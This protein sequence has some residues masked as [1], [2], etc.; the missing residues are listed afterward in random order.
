MNIVDIIERISELVEKSHN[1]TVF[2]MR[3]FREYL[4]GVPDK[5]IADAVMFVANRDELE[6]VGN[7]TVI[8]TGGYSENHQRVN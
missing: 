5:K 2:H 8:K 7:G 3:D 4:K 6:Y 1:G